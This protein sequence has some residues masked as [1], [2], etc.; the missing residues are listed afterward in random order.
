MF[1]QIRSKIEANSPACEHEEVLAGKHQADKRT[2]LFTICLGLVQDRL[3]LGQELGSSS[4]S[5]YSLDA[6][7]SIFG[8]GTAIS[9]PLEKPSF[10]LL[11]T[12][13]NEPD[14]AECEEHEAQHDQCEMPR[15]RKSDGKRGQE[16][17]KSLY[18]DSD[19]IG[20]C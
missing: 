15:L 4:K 5:D 11:V 14:Q 1:V 17:G 18:H 3:V 19:S 9:I 6:S 16:H 13:H 8:N 10:Y 7:K 20:Q 2:P 12:A